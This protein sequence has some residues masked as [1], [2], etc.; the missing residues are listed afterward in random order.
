MS[1]DTLSLFSRYFWLIVFLVVA[2]NLGLMK[3]LAAPLVNSRRI[4]QE[5]L[6]S[7]CRGALLMVGASGLAFGV[8]QALSE[9]PDPLCLM[10]LPPRELVGTMAWVLLGLLD[11][12][13]FAWLWTRNGA[14]LIIKIGPAFIWPL[15]LLGRVTPTVIRPLDHE[16]AVP[17]DYRAMLTG[18]IVI[19]QGLGILGVL[20]HP[21][22]LPGC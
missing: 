10:R 14:H 18:A 16:S 1:P 7:F 2:I 6:D 4:S 19:A 3:W 11:A 20:I 9:S 17:G 5:E 21:Q 22:G 13:L 15:M 12:W 8:L